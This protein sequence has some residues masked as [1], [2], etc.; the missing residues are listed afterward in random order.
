[1][2]ELIMEIIFLVFVILAS[3][4]AGYIWGEKKTSRPSVN[5]ENLVSQHETKILI[6]Q[7]DLKE[8]KKVLKL[9]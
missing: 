9:K 6:L 4:E 1:M 3:W 2:K 8:V 5:I 7:S